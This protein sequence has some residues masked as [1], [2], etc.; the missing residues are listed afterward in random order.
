ML[1]HR[2][3]DAVMTLYA[4]CYLAADLMMTNHKKLV[5]KLNKEGRPSQNRRVDLRIY[6]STWLGYL[7]VTAE[8]FK[9]LGM[10]KLLEFQRPHEFI[11]LIEPANRVGTTIK[12]HDDALRKLRNSVFHIRKD[13]NEIRNF[14]YEKPGR[15]EWADELQSTFKD[16]FSAYRIVFDVYCVLNDRRD[17][18]SL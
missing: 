5:T 14:F 8:G 12:K 16:F 15:L 3:E 2:D 10:R 13:S 18:A 4:H 11:E 17:E 1:P 9:G 7:A 6:A